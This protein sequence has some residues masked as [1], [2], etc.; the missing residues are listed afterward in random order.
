MAGQ[1]KIQTPTLLLVSENGKKQKEKEKEGK[2]E[3]EYR[4]G[5]K[6]KTTP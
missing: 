5:K 2:E 3:G 4:D 1:R 6:Q